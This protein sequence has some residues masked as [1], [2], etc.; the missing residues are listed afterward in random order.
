MNGWDVQPEAVEIFSRT[1]AQAVAGTPSKM[2]FDATSYD[3]ELCYTVDPALGAAAPTEIFASSALKYSGGV[4]IQ[5][6]GG[7]AQ[8]MAVD[9]V[10]DHVLL[11][12]KGPSTTASGEDLDVCVFISK[13]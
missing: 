8:Y 5:L 13:K 7:A 6:S 3:F 4:A 12:Y 11:T 1:Y 9:M 10:T 2:K